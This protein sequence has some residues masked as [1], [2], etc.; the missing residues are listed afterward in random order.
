MPIS[1]LGDMAGTSPTEMSVASGGGGSATDGLGQI[2]SGAGTVGSALSRAS[3][4]LGTGGGQGGMGDMGGVLGRMRAGLG[5]T[6]QFSGGP[7]PQV[8]AGPFKKGGKVSSKG[9]DWHGFGS[10]KT[11]NTNHGF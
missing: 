11:G 3:A 6:P 2:N 4:A 5:G 7:A 1:Q 9:R 8:T 10:S